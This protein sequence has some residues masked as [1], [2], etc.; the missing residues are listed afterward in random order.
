MPILRPL[1]AG[2]LLVLA[3][4]APAAAQNTI[5]LPPGITIPRVTALRLVRA[6]VDVRTD[7]RVTPRTTAGCVGYVKGDGTQLMS[8]DLE[9]GVPYAL[10]QIGKTVQLS[11]SNR[12]PRY[13]SALTQ[14]FDWD[15]RW[16]ECA[17][18]PNSEYGECEPQAQPT[19]NCTP[20]PVAGERPM[21]DIYNGPRRG[22]SGDPLMDE[23][24]A[25][26]DP[27][28]TLT[29]TGDT[30]KR[31]VDCPPSGDSAGNAIQLHMVGGQ[32]WTGG[33]WITALQRLRPG[34]RHTISA[35]STWG[36]SRPLNGRDKGSLKGC[37]A[38]PRA[39]GTWWCSRDSVRLTFERL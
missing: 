32:S 2:L 8:V 21:I 11:P 35:R 16:D 26:D 13:R 30:A 19:F 38:K 7:W 28:T 17:C 15:R 29:A 24:L 23:L 37:P 18:G 27:D 10:T 31:F 25:S 3:L 4:A 6:N 33:A 12:L 20:R 5:G 22:D 9:K 1:L 36:I 39:G 34:Q 14:L